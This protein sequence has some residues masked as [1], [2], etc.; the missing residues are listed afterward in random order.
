MFRNILR[1]Y[2]Q[3][4]SDKNPEK[5][6]GQVRARLQGVHVEGDDPSEYGRNSNNDFNHLLVMT[7]ISD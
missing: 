1:E 4:Y 3:A 7:L 5:G 6:D 2:R